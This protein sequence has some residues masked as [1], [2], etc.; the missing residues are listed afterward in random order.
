MGYERGQ[1]HDCPS[2][3]FPHGVG[4]GDWDG[5]TVAQAGAAVGP[6]PFMQAW[7]VA[8]T[9]ER[10]VRLWQCDTLIMSALY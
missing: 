7:V 6:L 4:R 3:P 10:F 1:Q 9:N 2:Q 5:A 8:V